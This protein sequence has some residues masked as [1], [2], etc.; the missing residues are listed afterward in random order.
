MKTAGILMILGIS[1][2]LSASIC[3]YEKSKID[4]CDKMVFL[5]SKVMILL[6]TT[7]PETEKIFDLLNNSEKLK[8][9]DL[10]NI[11]S[12]SPL[13]R[14]EN[15]KIYDYINSIGKYDS[16]TQINGANEFCETFRILKDY[17]TAHYKIIYALGLGIG[18]LIAILLI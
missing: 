10:N 13:K 12:S 9:I 3:K 6:K 18:C 1:I 16:Q 5:G 15:E 8:D 7:N 17:Y 4:Y 11:I 2:L 14:E